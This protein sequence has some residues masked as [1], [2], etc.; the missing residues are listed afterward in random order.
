LRSLLALFALVCLAPAQS[1]ALV[2]STIVTEDFTI[3]KGWA[4]FL[5]D[6]YGASNVLAGYDIDNT[7]MMREPGQ[8]LGTDEW[9]TWQASLY[10]VNKKALSPMAVAPEEGGL[11]T[12]FERLVSK[13]QL[14][15]VDERA[16]GVVSAIQ[17]MGIR[18]LVLTARSPDLRS[19]TERELQRNQYVFTRTLPTNP[20]GTVNVPTT[21][22]PYDPLVPLASGL[23]ADD[24]KDFSLAQAPAEPSPVS[25][26]DGV[27]MVAG[28]HKGA[29]LRTL[30]SRERWM[31][32]AI[33]YIDDTPAQILKM[34]AAF[35]EIPEVDLVTIEYA[36]TY[37]RVFQFNASDKTQ[38]VTD[39]NAF[40]R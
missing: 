11:F 30:L 33:L 14:Q 31:P 34:Q 10:D 9:F 29:M 27:F 28:Q 18:S 21:F 38:V 35:Q 19:A 6:R 17:N 13:I 3:M 7:L 4:Q 8:E 12:A 32:K 24:L 39:W 37:P 36:K 40:N 1:W 23:T 16:P 26:S 22:L 15:P 25:F 2:R 5:S 20:P